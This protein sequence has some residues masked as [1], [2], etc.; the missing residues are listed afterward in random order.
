[1]SL[2]NKSINFSENKNLSSENANLKDQANQDT[3]INIQKN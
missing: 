3:N 2:R 1:M